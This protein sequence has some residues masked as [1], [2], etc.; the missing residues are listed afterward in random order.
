MRESG[1]EIGNSGKSSRN[2][3][4][5]RLRKPVAKAL[6]GVYC[7]EGVFA[8]G[9]GG[10]AIGASRSSWTLA[11]C[12]CRDAARFCISSRDM[13]E[14]DEGCELCRP[15]LAHL[16]IDEREMRFF[17]DEASDCRGVSCCETVLEEVTGFGNGRGGT[18]DFCSRRTLPSLVCVGVS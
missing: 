9:F 16:K 11:P 8:K 12:V 6:G 13:F 15:L 14:K 2:L 10:S 7:G 3:D 18:G 4:L 17:F 5:V 1:G